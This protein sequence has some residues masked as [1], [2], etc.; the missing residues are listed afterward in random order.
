M[1]HLIA[2]L[3]VSTLFA[4][5]PVSVQRAEL[6]VAFG[7]VQGKIVVLADQMVFVDDEKP[8]ASFAIP[9]REVEELRVDGA[10]VTARLRR[11]V[12]DREGE[13][14]RLNLRLPEGSSPAALQAFFDRTTMTGA[15]AKKAEGAK[16]EAAGKDAPVPAGARTFRAR[17]KHV[18]G[19][20]EGRLVLL[21]EQIN[22]ESI[23][24]A[25]HSR[26]WRFQDIKELKRKNPFELKL[27][28]FGADEYEFEVP[29]PVIDQPD[30]QA[31]IDG[32]TRARIA[33]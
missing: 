27:Q 5:E 24:E 6:A 20:C 9:R 29:S 11:P 12:R 31:L 10:M 25:G 33:R 4:Q 19:G 2:S 3:A 32:I 21:D 16:G 18:F 22:F 8:E 7:T 13:R 17:H 28:P 30:Y 14:T 23:G 15:D 26:R 1:K